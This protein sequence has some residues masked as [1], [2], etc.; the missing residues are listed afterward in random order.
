VELLE[1]R[2]AFCTIGGLVPTNR[3]QTK[4]LDQVRIASRARHYSHRTETTYVTWI[5][6]FIFFHNKRHPKEMAETE[7]NQFLTHLAVNE[8]VSGSTQNQALSALIF[9]YRYLFERPLGELGNVIRA[10]PSKR[11]PV[12]LT[13]EEVKAVLNRLK[14]EQRLIALLRYAQFRSYWVTN[15]LRRQ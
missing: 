11:L 15:M 3:T 8:K 4:L 12:V 5:K 9:L 1:A 7:V 6:R 14:G 10:R 13:C 2:D